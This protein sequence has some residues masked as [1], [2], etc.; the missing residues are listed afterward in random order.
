VK[1]GIGTDGQETRAAK[2]NA[3]T[4]PVPDVGIS[5]L[6]YK[7]LAAAL[8]VCIR[9]VRRWV[10]QGVLPAPIHLGRSC[11]FDG[12]EIRAVIEKLKGRRPC[13]AME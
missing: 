3:S 7:Q 10:A 5:P 2:D 8:G 4:L 12:V 6:S 1:N 9:T 13:Y 11:R